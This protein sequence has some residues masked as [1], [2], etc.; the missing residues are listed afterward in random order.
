MAKK[1]KADWYKL[2]C[3]KCDGE[4]E[5]EN[6]KGKMKK[7]K[8]CEGKG[9][10]DV[11]VDECYEC[12]GDRKVEC[13]CTGGLGKKAADDDCP[14]CGGKGRHVCPVCDGRGYDADC[15]KD[16]GVAIDELWLDNEF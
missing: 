5:I 16:A 7:C 15:L 8:K 13:D 9:K 11:Y 1:F 6:S 12:G 3:K 10:I 4:G 2:D 14:A